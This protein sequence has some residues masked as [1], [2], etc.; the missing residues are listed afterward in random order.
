MDEVAKARNGDG[1]PLEISIH[2]VVMVMF[3]PPVTTHQ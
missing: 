1:E 2:L 3:H